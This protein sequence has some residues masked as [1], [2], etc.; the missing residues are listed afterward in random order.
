MLQTKRTHLRNLCQED[1]PVLFDYRNDARCNR[2]QRYDDTSILYLQNFVRAYSGCVFLSTEEEQHYAIVGNRGNELLGDISIFYSEEDNCFT[3]GITIAPL[4]QQQ[5]YAYELLKEVVF[6]LQQ[7]H[8]TVDIVALIEKG[9][10]RSIA[11]FKKLLFT[12]ECYAEPIQ[13]YVFIKYPQM[14]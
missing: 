10:K 1:V 8:P 3:L 6:Q 4:Y 9:N 13:S 7:H 11:L 12:E 2:Y 14:G 5:G